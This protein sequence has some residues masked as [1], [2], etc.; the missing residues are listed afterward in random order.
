VSGFVGGA[1]GIVRALDRL[2]QVEKANAELAK[3]T[4]AELKALRQEMAT[5]RE[6]QTRLESRVDQVMIQ[7]GAA[8]Q[9]AA[10]LA[11]AGEIGAVRERLALLEA[12]PSKGRTSG[13]A[14]PPP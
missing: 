10:A 6:A 9:S 2:S 11:V 3:E 1:V 12:R 13:R 4:R 8:A 5:L 14:L 7:A